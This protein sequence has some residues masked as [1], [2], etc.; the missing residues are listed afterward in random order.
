[1]YKA[2]SAQMPFWGW[3]IYVHLLGCCL[4]IAHQGLH[5]AG[6]SCLTKGTPFP[7]GSQHP[8]MAYVGLMSSSFAPTHYNSKEASQLQSSPRGWLR[9]LLLLQDSPTFPR[10][11]F[12]P[13]WNGHFSFLR[14]RPTQKTSC[15]PS[16]TS[17]PAAWGRQIVTFWRVVHPSWVSP[18]GVCWDPS[19]VL[20]G[21]ALHIPQALMP[22]EVSGKMVLQPQCKE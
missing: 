19:I 18:S 20:K 21:A 12:L 1:M 14:A 2:F 16:S 17:E 10:P 8:M 6:E 3:R 22:F 5:S 7:W 4:L 9:S 13:L 11:N 15:K